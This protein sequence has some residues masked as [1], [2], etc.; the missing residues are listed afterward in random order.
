MPQTCGD[1]G[2]YDFDTHESA[3]YVND[4]ALAIELA[5]AGAA[6]S[7]VLTVGGETVDLRYPGAESGPR[8]GRTEPDPARRIP[9]TILKSIVWV[10]ANWA[11]A[12][13]T[14]PYGGV[15]PTLRSFDCGYGLGQIT[16]GMSNDTG[17]VTAKQAIVG[18][19]PLYN[20][21]EG[22][23]ILVSKWNA[24]P[25]RL[26][27][28]GRGDPAAFE[29]W[30]YAIW[31]YNGF[32]FGN[33][34][35]NPL[36]DPLRKGNET[37]PLYHCF[38]PKAHS[39]QDDGAGYVKFGYGD[40]TY[41]E[42][43]YGCMK[44]PPRYYPDELPGGATA[45]L[46]GIQ[47]A[48]D[49][50]LAPGETA[51]VSAAGDC[52]NLRP[53]PDTS[54]DPIA[55]LPDGTEVTLLSGPVGAEGIE[56]WE[57]DSAAGTGWVAGLYLVSG[58]PP[59]SPTPAPSPTPVTPPVPLPPPL[60][61][62][63]RLW[64]AAEFRMPE[65]GHPLIASA[66]APAVFDACE[67]LSFAGGCPRMD[68][69]TDIPDW[70]ISPHTDQTPPVDPAGA[71]ALIGE[72]RLIVNGPGVIVV[73]VD[74]DNPEAG[75]IVTV[76]NIG[77]GIAPFRVRTTHP[78]ILV[79]HPQDDSART[80]DAG[81]TVGAE[82]DVVLSKDPLR[83]QKGYHSRLKVTVDPARAPQGVTTGSII[84]EP[85][86]GGAPS[87]VIDVTAWNEDGP[88]VRYYTIGLPNV[89]RD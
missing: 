7:D 67:Q 66:F 87:I 47:Q 44:Y 19:H 81:V 49:G 68:F 39:Y 45:G 74:P 69:P 80:L 38:E 12:D 85:L 2:P 27:V 53:T 30:Y 42:R 65:F 25:E 82:I 62:G 63:P 29:D 21:A 14:V 51:I 4:Y 46:A 3:N 35:L 88:P 17:T 57:V 59:P 33:H 22:A 8:D 41:Q 15:G 37:S 5:A 24:A 70:S 56:W 13:G 34:P 36:L 73:K 55:C 52:L 11:N 1:E 77:S 79:R 64:K 50:D 43:V 83:T 54:G 9:P 75:D 18:T 60:L 86:L 6:V 40:Y 89:G 48:L 26:P 31:A 78:W 58:G 76:S 72:P 10:E 16:T 32:W 61:D 71:A 28:A 84:I 23:R 20:L